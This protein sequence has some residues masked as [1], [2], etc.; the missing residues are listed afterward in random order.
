MPFTIDRFLK[1]RPFVY[2]TTSARSFI[3]IQNDG[4]L[5]SATKMLEGTKFENVLEERRSDSI[6][7]EI[8]GKTVILRDNRPLLPGSLALPDGWS[9]ADWLRELNSWVF[10]WP[11]DSERPIGRGR[12]HYARYAAQ[13]DVIVLRLPLVDLT[14]TNPD[15][16]LYLTSC[17]S[18]AAR[19]HNGRPATR[20]PRIFQTPSSACFAARDSVEVTFRDSIRIPDGATWATNLDGPWRGFRQCRSA[21]HFSYKIVD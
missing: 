16:P 21:S 12:S 14:S 9:L 4:L 3:T 18:G 7:F 2:H 15:N 17:N 11:G 19:H 6:E 13:S 8:D 1:L 5:K 10:L 20:G